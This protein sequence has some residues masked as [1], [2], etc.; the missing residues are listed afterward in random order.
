MLHQSFSFAHEND[1][2][3]EHK[4]D[5]K[6]VVIRLLQGAGRYLLPRLPHQHRTDGTDALDSLYLGVKYF[7]YGGGD[8]FACS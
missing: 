2:A 3:L 6:D 8:V 7:R 4:E 5:F 1:Y